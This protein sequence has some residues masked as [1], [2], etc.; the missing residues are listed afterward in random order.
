MKTVRC[1][2][3][4]PVI[5]KDKWIYPWK[6]FTGV[7]SYLSSEYFYQVGKH[8]LPFFLSLHAHLAMEHVLETLWNL[9][10][11]QFPFRNLMFVY[12]FLHGVLCSYNMREILEWW[13]ARTDEGTMSEIRC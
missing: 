9:L 6:E 12:D 4:L 3:K 5:D 7:A 8:H 13:N 1:L 10:F 11:V 2:T